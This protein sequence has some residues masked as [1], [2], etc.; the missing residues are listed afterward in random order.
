M[1]L[2]EDYNEDFKKQEYLGIYPYVEY[3]KTRESNSVK[4]MFDAK[5]DLKYGG[6]Y[7]FKIPYYP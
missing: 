5:C 6:F 2:T 3:T 4:R 1:P 7:C